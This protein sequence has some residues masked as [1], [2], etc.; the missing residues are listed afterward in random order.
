MPASSASSG[1]V[2]ASLPLQISL[3]FHGLYAIALIPMTLLMYIYKAIMLPYPPN[4]LGLEVTFVFVYAL[5]EWVRLRLGE[6]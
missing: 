4:A 6:L 1:D 3:F 2:K 5:L